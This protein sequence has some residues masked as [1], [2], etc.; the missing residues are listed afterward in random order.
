MN[1]CSGCNKNKTCPRAN[2]SDGFE[3]CEESE[4]V[5]K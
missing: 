3:V 4:G 2:E 1:A 5:S